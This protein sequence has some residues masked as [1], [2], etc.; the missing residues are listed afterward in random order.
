MDKTLDIPLSGIVTP[1]KLSAFFMVA[2]LFREIRL[3]IRAG[4]HP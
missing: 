3:D 4:D 1:Y 2:S